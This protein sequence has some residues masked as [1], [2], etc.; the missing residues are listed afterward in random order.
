MI[1]AGYITLNEIISMQPDDTT[2]L[3]TPVPASS[4]APAPTPVPAF[5]SDDPLT[6]RKTPK[7]LKIILKIVAAL[8]VLGAI[9][10]GVLF[11]VISQAVAAPLKVS[12]S[13]VDAVQGGDSVAAYALTT[14]NFQKA[15]SPERMAS[16]VE[17]TKAQIKGEEKVTGQS[18][19]TEDGAS[20]AAIS[21]AVTAQGK[22]V[23]MRVI[24]KKDGD[25]WKVNHFKLDD[26]PIDATTE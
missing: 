22:D 26:E 15:A 1:Y 4:P 25:T 20:S 14:D 9:L 24:L 17:A 10:A 11:F 8:I 2:P 21:Y 7:P 13:F 18:A 23:Y 5:Q 6:K 12:N 16:L 19:K 3:N